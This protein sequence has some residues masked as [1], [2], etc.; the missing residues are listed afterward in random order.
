MLHLR[1]EERH[2]QFGMTVGIL[3]EILTGTSGI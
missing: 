3:T 1:T 2:G